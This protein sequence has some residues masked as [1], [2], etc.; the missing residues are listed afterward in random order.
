MSKI[1]KHKKYK[2]NHLY[3]FEQFGFLHVRSS[4]ER[5][6]RDAGFNHLSLSLSFYVWGSGKKV[7]VLCDDAWCSPYPLFAP[8]LPIVF[9]Y[10]KEKKRKQ[11]SRCS[12]KLLLQLLKNL[13]Y[14]PIP[15]FSFHFTVG[16]MYSAVNTK[17]YN[18]PTTVR[19]MHLL[20]S[21]GS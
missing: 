11:S 18:T 2:L 20:A 9:R 15:L 6:C 5:K 17:Q 10:K 3:I 19:N 4:K 21:R 16:V 1:F 12:N 7:G 13:E 8:S 14:C